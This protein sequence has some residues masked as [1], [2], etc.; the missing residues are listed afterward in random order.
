[1]F[2][3]FTVVVRLITTLLT[4][5]RPAPTAPPGRP[6]EAGTAPPRD[7]G[8]APAKRRPANRAPHA[9]RYAAEEDDERRRVHGTRHDG[10]G[11][12][13]PE[14]AD[15]DPPAMM[16]RR[17]APGGIVQ[18]CP[19]EA[20][21]PNPPTRTIGHPARRRGGRDP[22]GPV[23]L[24][25]APAAVLVERF[26]P[27]HG[28]RRVARARGLNEIIRPLVVP[29]VP[30]G[31]LGR[32]PQLDPRGIQ[33]GEHHPLIGRNRY[34]AATGCGHGDGAAAVGAERGRILIDVH[35]IVSGPL[36]AERCL[37]GVQ[38]DAGNC[39][40]RY[41]PLCLWRLRGISGWVTRAVVRRLT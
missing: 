18:P 27:I 3:T 21:I 13:G 26:G 34:G 22:H 35:A 37:G 1:M 23:V 4:N 31:E 29:A 41:R 33:P 20:G 10:S 12:P 30:R 8:L 11:R 32:R 2:V 19:A 28:G 7:E 24:H 38:L 6:K 14:A 9:D 40:T 39:Y 36:D 25:G 17:P 15:E 16:V 5:S